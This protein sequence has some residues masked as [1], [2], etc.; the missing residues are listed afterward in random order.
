MRPNVAIF[1]FH[2]DLRLND[3][4]GLIKAYEWCRKH[5]AESGTL[6]A[7]AFILPLFILP[8]EQ[9]EPG[10]NR[11]FSLPAVRFMIESLDDLNSEL[12]SRLLLIEGNTTD[13][14]DRIHAS[15]NIDVVAFFTNLDYS[16]YAVERDHNI[17]KW[18]SKRGVEF[19]GSEDYN[20]VPLDAG[21]VEGVRPYMN[22]SQYYKRFLKDGTM[23]TNLDIR[24]FSWR[25]ERFLPKHYVGFGTGVVITSVEGLKKRFEV[26]GIKAGAE[27]IHGGR[28][29]AL[30]ILRRIKGGAYRDYW[31]ERDM[32]GIVKGTTRASAH[33]KFGTMSVREMYWAVVKGMGS[34]DNALVRELIFRD[35]Y[36]KIYANSKELQRGVA[37]RAELDSYI[38]WRG[39]KDKLWAAWTEGKTGIPLVDAGM[40]QLAA[41]GWMHNRIRM[42]VAS[43]A[44]RHFMLDWR[45]CARFFYAHLVDADPFSNTA[46]WQF[47]AGIGVDSAPYWRP[48]FNPFLQSK[49]FDPECVYI[50]RWLPEFRC[51]AKRDIHHWNE[52]DARTKYRGNCEYIA[53]VVDVRE[54]SRESMRIMKEANLLVAKSKKF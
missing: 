20:L 43:V 13:V 2:R 16:V 19:H 9:I 26:A 37:Y 54:A 50:R 44:T 48:P 4:R 22:L 28:R 53:P 29:E 51:V 12:N 39:T 49:R 15:H 42:V 7:T 33:L 3:N 10:K 30:K 24:A 34:F 27:E 36:L 47:M 1:L 52:E 8:P 31:K 35:F 18:C 41:E 5:N 17:R 25:A 40:R 11:Y 38:P 46:G 6:G 14:L 32:P 23:K 45:E 21:L